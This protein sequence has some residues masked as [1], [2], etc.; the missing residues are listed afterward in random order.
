MEEVGR[1]GNG[2]GEAED[3]K[4]MLY[5]R[6]SIRGMMDSEIWKGNIHQYSGEGQKGQLQGIFFVML[7]SLSVFVCVFV[8]WKLKKSFALGGVVGSANRY[9]MD[10]LPKK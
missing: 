1:R 5:V 6:N 9:F 3:L 8:C 4:G 7:R 10:L 2:M